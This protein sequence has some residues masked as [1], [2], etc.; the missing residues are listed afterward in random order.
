M[1]ELEIPAVSG[2]L[3]RYILFFVRIIFVSAGLHH[4]YDF[5]IPSLW[6]K[7]SVSEALD[8]RSCR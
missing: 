8:I 4:L 5:F 6:E 3:Q 1:E 7:L 2:K